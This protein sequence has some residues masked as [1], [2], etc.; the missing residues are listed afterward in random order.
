[1]GYK[2]SSIYNSKIGK[3]KGYQKMTDFIG[4]IRNNEHQRIW[5]IYKN[6]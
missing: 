1:M 3:K 4:R 2:L 5:F 6:I